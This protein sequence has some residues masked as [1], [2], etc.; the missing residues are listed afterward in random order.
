MTSADQCRLIYL[1]RPNDKS[2]TTDLLKD[3]LASSQSP[4][5]P[6]LKHTSC[7][8]LISTLVDFDESGHSSDSRVMQTLLMEIS[9]Q[10][11][12]GE[13]R[14]EKIHFIQLELNFSPNIPD[15]TALSLHAM[16]NFTIYVHRNRQFM[17]KYLM[18]GDMLDT[19][20]HRLESCDNFEDFDYITLCYSNLNRVLT[21]DLMELYK[22]KMEQLMRQGQLSRDSMTILRVNSKAIVHN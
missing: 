20:L 9:Q 19:L 5:I 7:N 2:N 3:T 11:K 16:A 15:P 22:T 10:M 12:E 14:I 8:D 13:F 18:C 17:H 1:K 6:S 21:E 4:E